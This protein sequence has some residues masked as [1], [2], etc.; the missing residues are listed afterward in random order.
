MTK[1]DHDALIAKA[2]EATGRVKGNFGCV[3]ELWQRAVNSE[4]ESELSSV[5]EEHYEEAKAL[6]I[7]RGFLDYGVEEFL[8]ESPCSHGLGPMECPGTCYEREGA[9]WDA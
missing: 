3:Y 8:A 5:P 2:T 9:V 1:L 4:V 6:L 7:E